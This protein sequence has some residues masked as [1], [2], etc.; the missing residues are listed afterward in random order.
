MWGTGMMYVQDTSLQKLMGSHGDG[1]IPIALPA[2]EEL[3]S[4]KKLINIGTLQ[5]VHE[6]LWIIAAQRR[7][8]NPV[9]AVIMKDFKI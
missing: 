9:A 4:N 2:A 1:L 5:D 3:I 8:Q 7:I 6:E